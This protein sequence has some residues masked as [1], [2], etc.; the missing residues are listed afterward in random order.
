VQYLGRF[1]LA[2]CFNDEDFTHWFLPRDNIVE[3]YVVEQDGKITDLFSFYSLPSTV[4]SHPT[5][6]S[7]R[8]AYSF[9]NVSTKTAWPELMSDALIVAK[10]V[11]IVL[12]KDVMHI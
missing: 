12:T 4:M 1:N 6:K 10:K 3:C 5:H 8:A 9:Y 11:C 2:P 7:L